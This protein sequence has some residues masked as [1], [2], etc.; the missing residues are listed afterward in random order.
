MRASSTP[1]QIRKRA[2]LTAPGWYL[3]QSIEDNAPK[4]RCRVRWE[5]FQ[6]DLKP[7]RERIKYENLLIKSNYITTAEA[8][9]EYHM[10]T[11][12]AEI[13]YLYVP[14]YAVSDSAVTVTEDDLKAYYNKNI[15]RY[16]TEESRDM[17]Y[18]SIPVEPSSDDTRCSA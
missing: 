15:E 9:R 1:L 18:I 8:E 6:R 17:K 3:H 14:F 7:G 11:D 5:I 4:L 16:K 2:N 10:Q 13:K 12:V